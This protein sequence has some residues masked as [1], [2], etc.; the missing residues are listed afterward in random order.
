MLRCNTRHTF[1]MEALTI[2]LLVL[3]S[4]Q[5]CRVALK[6]IRCSIPHIYVYSNEGFSLP[7]VFL[8]TQK[9]NT[10]TKDPKCP[11]KNH[12]M[13]S[14]LQGEMG[15]NM[16]SGA[17][18]LGN[19]KAIGPSSLVLLLLLCLCFFCSNLCF[20]LLEASDGCWHQRIL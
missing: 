7:Y 3:L 13:M 16:D 6:S 18:C 14:V 15:S 10:K 12:S 19:A 11:C 20:N 1:Q 17:I 4:L 2:T 9:L 5:Y 8:Q